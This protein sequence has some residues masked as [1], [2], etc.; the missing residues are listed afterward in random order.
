ME[1]LALLEP[2]RGQFLGGLFAFFVEISQ[3]K[4]EYK[5]QIIEFESETK[6]VRYEALEAIEREVA[7]R[8]SQEDSAK[9]LNFQTERLSSD[10]K[11]VANQI[12]KKC[13]EFTGESNYAF[14]SNRRIWEKNDIEEFEKNQ[15]QEARFS[16]QEKSA[17]QEARVASFQGFQGLPPPPRM[18]LKSEQAEV[19]ETVEVA[20]QYGSKHRRQETFVTFGSVSSG[21]SSGYEASSSRGSKDSCQA[22]SG[23]DE[24]SLENIDV[25]ALYNNVAEVL[26]LYHEN[27][28]QKS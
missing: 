4:K 3:A 7:K 23:L 14:S 5:A 25:E 10:T 13:I 15:E 9:L 26:D 24:D 8:I 11:R 12:Y 17:Q 20:V 6:K 22:A 1:T 2:R 16:C 18:A 19:Q 28:D 21:G 27:Y